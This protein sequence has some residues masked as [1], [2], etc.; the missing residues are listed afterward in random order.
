MLV[1]CCVII[2]VSKPADDGKREHRL[3]PRQ[4]SIHIIIILLSVFASL[5]SCLS[6]CGH[7]V[8]DDLSQDAL[9]LHD[10]SAP[11]RSTWGSYDNWH[12]LYFV[13]RPSFSDLQ[14]ASCSYS[15]FLCSSS[16]WF[17]SLE[18]ATW[19]RFCSLLHQVFLLFTL[20]S[21]DTRRRMSS[22]HLHS[23][24]LLLGST[25]LCTRAHHLS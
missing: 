19:I 8:T 23:L 21:S 13:S 4:H 18:Q 1:C 12:Y 6:I 14:N 5:I 10:M 3:M 24:L 20:F 22:G 9:R 15:V 17:F 7:D 11:H 2:P 16:H 25:S